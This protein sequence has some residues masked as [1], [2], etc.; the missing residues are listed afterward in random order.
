MVRKKDTPTKAAL[1]EM[2]SREQYKGQ[3]II[4]GRA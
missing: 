4:P 3:V 2:M 1:R